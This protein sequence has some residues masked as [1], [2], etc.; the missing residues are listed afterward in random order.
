MDSRQ[1]ARHQGIASSEL[2]LPL[3]SS[4]LLVR[5]LNK[6]GRKHLPVSPVPVRSTTSA[7]RRGGVSSSSMGGLPAAPAECCFTPGAGTG[8]GGPLSSSSLT[9]I[10]SC[11]CSER[12]GKTSISLWTCLVALFECAITGCSLFHS[13]H[14]VMW[15]SISDCE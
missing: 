3:L 7:G 11:R 12:E 5:L 9:S 8:A 6:C 4:Q 15:I 1:Y 2:A 14:H 10:W 13:R